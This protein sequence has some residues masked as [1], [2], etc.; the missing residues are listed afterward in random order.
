MMYFY[1]SASCDLKKMTELLSL[2]ILSRADDDYCYVK[3]Q[4]L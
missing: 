2:K 3:N 4:V 1:M